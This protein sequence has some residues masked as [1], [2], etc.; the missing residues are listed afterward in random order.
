MC[1]YN[2]NMVPAY[3]VYT[4]YTHV[5]SGKSANAHV[6]RHEEDLKCPVLSFSVLFL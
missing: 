3:V 2:V 6:C 4:Q 1:L 5:C